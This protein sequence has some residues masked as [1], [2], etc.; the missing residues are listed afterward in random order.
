MSVH[1]FQIV[2]AKLIASPQLC[3]RALADEATVFADYILTEKEKNRLHAVLRQRGM[4][5]CCSL[6]RMN[7]V[8]PLYSQLSNTCTLLGDDLVPIIKAFWKH[9]SETSLQ[10][11]EEVLAFGHFLTGSDSAAQIPYLQ[12]VLQLEIAMNELSYLP[13]GE[14]RYLTFEHDIYAILQA[15]AA[16][17]LHSATIG[18]SD[19]T[20]KMCIIDNEIK[21]DET[22]MAHRQTQTDTVLLS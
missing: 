3:R 14:V 12:E 9:M 7:R 15:I 1:D 8:T 16:G 6:Y 19:T 11:K 4:S 5:A 18:R 2:L 20:Y 13:E 21:M 10:F 22:V 17:T